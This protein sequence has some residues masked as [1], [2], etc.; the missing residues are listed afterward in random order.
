M[1]SDERGD[2][3]GT[4][5]DAALATDVDSGDA[6]SGTAMAALLSFIAIDQLPA[7]AGSRADRVAGQIVQALPDANMGA[8]GAAPVGQGDEAVGRAP[9]PGRT[10]EV[11]AA[12][13]GEWVQGLRMSTA[14]HKVAVVSQETHLSMLSPAGQMVER[15]VAQAGGAEKHGQ[16]GPPAGPADARRLA[17]GARAA[18]VSPELPTQVAT[19]TAAGDNGNN[20][21]R[22]ADGANAATA[23]RE[24]P[25]QIVTAKAAGDKDTDTSRSADGVRAATISRELRAQVKTATAAG[26]K[27]AGQR[28]TG[29]SP[30][31]G[32]FPRFPVAQAQETTSQ[33]QFAPVDRPDAV[34][35]KDEQLPG[36]PLQQIAR[37]VVMAALAGTDA[38]APAEAHALSVAPSPAATIKVL[39]IQLQPVELGTI[40][41]RMALHH[42]ALEL[43]LEV[44]RPE[45]ARLLQRDRDKLSEILRSAG[46]QVD[47]VAVRVVDRDAVAPPGQSSPG[48]L[49]GST[50]SQAGSSRPDARPWRGHG[51]PQPNRQRTN[52]NGSDEEG[53]DQ[54][55]S[56]RDI[57][58]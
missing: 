18:T 34:V 53:R 48:F 9:S 58:V 45:T 22:S 50:Q 3:A 23:S 26:D 10:R 54:R 31:N 55:R 35:G 33:D 47:G 21:K 15:I 7:S 38:P 32:G 12:D 13:I 37:Q 49:D 52:G 16:S 46:Y 2:N 36:P 14:R 1:A 4:T 24:L 25:A 43:Q 39:T 44:G 57:Y 11:H 5:A 51:E 40:A 41:V 8:V 28:F 56:G 27:D 42:N 6:A 20:T 19:A 30:G 17:G 29:L